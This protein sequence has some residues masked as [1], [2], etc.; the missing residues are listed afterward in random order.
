MER[1][2]RLGLGASLLLAIVGCSDTTSNNGAVGGTASATSGGA[3]NSGGTSGSDTSS[4]TGGQSTVGTTLVPQG[5]ASSTGGSLATG[6]QQT[7]GGSTS[8]GGSSV[9]GGSAAT[10]GKAAG[11]ASAATGGKAAGGSSAL[12]STGGTSASAGSKASGG[13]ATGGGSTLS[14]GG[15]SATGGSSPATGGMPATGGKTSATTIGPE[16][17]GEITF[18]DDNGNGTCSYGVTGETDVA[19]LA[20][21]SWDDAAWCGACAEV[22]GSKGTIKVKVVNQ[23]PTCGGAWD[24][25]LNKSAFLKIEEERVGRYVDTWHFVPCGITTPVKY[26]FKEGSSSGWTAV[27]VSDNNLPITKLEW[28]PNQNSWQTA[29]REYYNYFVATSGFG[30]GPMYVRITAIDGQQLID[31]LPSVEAGRVVTGE[32]NFE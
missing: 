32:S 3:T 23:C 7:S 14:T 10:G 5:G 19:A 20:V 31:Q 26:R 24:L 1:I 22:S 28:S 6:G 29:N 15:V 4:M 9:G 30:I 17:T 18:Y 21:G 16:H 11:G 13:A 12:G 27:M 8:T 2:T 25:D